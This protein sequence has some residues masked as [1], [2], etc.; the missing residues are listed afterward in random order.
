MIAEFWRREAWPRN[1]TLGRD[2][3]EL[4]DTAGLRVRFSSWWPCCAPGLRGGRGRGCAA[5]GRCATGSVAGTSPSRAPGR[6]QRRP[7]PPPPRGGNKGGSARGAEPRG[8]GAERL[9]VSRF[10]LARFVPV[11]GRGGEAGS[12]LKPR[13]GSAACSR[14]LR[15]GGEGRRLRAQRSIV[16]RRGTPCSRAPRRGAAGRDGAAAPAVR[17]RGRRGWSPRGVSRLCQL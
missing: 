10:V 4:G 6:A 2:V 14:I 5:Q 17:A 1:H 12:D 13:S 15:P 9:V 11:G 7:S 3:Y 16:R 8:K